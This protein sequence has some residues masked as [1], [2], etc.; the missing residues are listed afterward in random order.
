M[1]ISPSLTAANRS[2]VEAFEDG[3]ASGFGGDFLIRKF[4]PILI[5]D[6]FGMCATALSIRKFKPIWGTF[7]KRTH[8]P[9][10]L[11][12]PCLYHTKKANPRISAVRC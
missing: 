11:S 10:Q 5:G 3:A 9:T 12:P 7:K 2:Q 6:S 8:L 1:V 4:E